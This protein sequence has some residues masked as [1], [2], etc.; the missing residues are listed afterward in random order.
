MSTFGAHPGVNWISLE[1]MAVYD[2]GLGP[3]PALYVGGYFSSAGGVEASY[4]ARWDG[5]QWYDVAGGVDGRV[6]AMAVFDDGGPGGS[7]LFVGGSFVT[8]GGLPAKGIA[9]WDGVAWQDVGGGVV[10]GVGV[11]SLAVF[12]DGSGEALYA[13]GW[14]TSA[15]GNPVARIAKWNGVSWSDVGGGMDAAV[16]A[17]AVDSVAGHLYA[18]GYFDHAGGVQ[19]NHIARWDGNSW[20]AVG[21]GFGDW[22]QALVVL[23]AGVFG[24]AVLVA[25]GK[26]PGYISKW[27][28][29][30]WSSIDGG[31]NGPV[32]A[33]LVSNAVGDGVPRL[34]AGGFFTNAGGVSASKIAS[35]DGQSWEALGTGMSQNRVEAIIEFDGGSVGGPGIFAGGSFHDAGGL[36]ANRFARW[37]G[38]VWDALS[39]G[40][41]TNDVN[42]VA[43]FDD[44]LG[45]GPQIYV[46]GV[47]RGAGGELAQHLA[48]WD[49]SAWHAVGGGLN[50]WVHA[51]AVFDDG[52]GDGPVLYVGGEFSASGSQVLNAIARWNGSEFVSVGGGVDGRVYSLLPSIDPLTG[53]P[54]LYVGGDFTSAGG[55]PASRIASWDGLGWEALGGGVGSRVSALG[56]LDV[57]DERA[58][59]YVGGFFTSVDGQPAQ[60]LARWD[61]A[62]WSVPW[63]TDGPVH[64]IRSAPESDACALYIGGDFSRVG[65]DALTIA[66]NG[67]V[68]FDDS[69]L[70]TLGVG[71]DGPVHAISILDLADG[72]GPRVFVG[73]QFEHAGGGHARHIA[74]WNGIAWGPIGDGVSDWV[75]DLA[76]HD[77]GD[78][79]GVS[80]I[81]GGIFG[82]SPAGDSYLA[83]WAGDPTSTIAADLDRDGLVGFSDLLLLLERWGDCP[84]CALC[85]A[86]FGR[87][88][89]VG[90]EDLMELLASWSS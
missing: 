26:F 82:A 88:G 11:G 49:G 86:D 43:V 2:D 38:E 83:R 8:A 36:P 57:P 87:D 45:G 6:M 9:R 21:N 66:A 53:Q 7:A 77:A 30:S 59:L 68:R 44:G 90:F 74:S 50:G 5:E 81:V 41:L 55:L 58:G 78:G 31:M 54:K 33:L 79:C 25:G 18:G 15:G 52:G 46:G 40:G 19:A 85:P 10:A 3:G 76:S 14:F 80:L 28:G 24:D 32:Y 65:F 4:I 48:R 27:N 64:V 60:Y 35:W 61:G 37:D 71:V 17:L 13:G 23:P 56:Y 69:G 22:V 16:V 62:S 70:R 34:Y 63:I 67:I 73:G 89:A 84:G 42:T 72:G 39:P 20:S 75:Y 47:L 12:D 29:S 1:S 51:M